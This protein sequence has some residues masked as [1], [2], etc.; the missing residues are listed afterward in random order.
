M[1]GTITIIFDTAGKATVV[2]K[3]IKGTSCTD[4]SKEFEALLLDDDGVDI[5]TSE[6]YQRETVKEAP[7]VKV[8][9]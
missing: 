6:F 2:V 9:K 1:N 3:G 5:K 4:L 8:G 7:R